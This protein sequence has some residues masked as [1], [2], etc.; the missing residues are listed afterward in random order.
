ME[1]LRNELAHLNGLPSHVDQL[2]ETVAAD[3]LVVD[4]SAGVV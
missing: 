3:G 2:R 1:Q 4:G